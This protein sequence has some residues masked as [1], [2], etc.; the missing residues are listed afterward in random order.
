MASLVGISTALQDPYSSAVPGVAV[1]P[2]AKV[3]LLT[4]PVLE[5]T[6]SQIST[7][8]ESACATW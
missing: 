2:E 7:Y 5:I 8:R 3:F 4:P 1:S 6:P